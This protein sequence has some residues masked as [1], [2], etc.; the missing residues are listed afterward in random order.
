MSIGAF[1][2]SEAALLCESA[3]G[4]PR[5][6]VNLD[7]RSKFPEKPKHRKTSP[8][9]VSQVQRF[10]ANVMPKVFVLIGMGHSQRSRVQTVYLEF[11]SRDDM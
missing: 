10:S 4:Q 5:A 2:A 7:P 9:E 11:V 8:L 3:L 6:V 1:A